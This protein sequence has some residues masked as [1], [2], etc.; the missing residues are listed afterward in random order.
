MCAFQPTVHQ[1]ALDISAYTFHYQQSNSSHIQ[2]HPVTVLQ[3]HSQLISRANLLA[4]RDALNKA[5]LLY[6]IRR[7]ACAF[8][9]SRFG[10]FNSFWHVI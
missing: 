1:H 10:T 6:P 7:S 4:T 3:G 9:E 2:S 8:C 5:L